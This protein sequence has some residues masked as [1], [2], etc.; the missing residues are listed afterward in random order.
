GAE[1]RVSFARPD[2]PLGYGYPAVTSAFRSNYPVYDVRR[3]DRDHVVLT[4]GTRPLKDERTEDESAGESEDALVVSGGVRN[5]DDLEGHPAILDVPV[6][7]GHVIAF[8]FNPLHRDLNHSDY[9]F[10]WNALLNWRHILD[11]ENP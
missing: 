6:G 10:L 5:G 11:A 2:H 1:L 9:R 3:A 7:D 8:N 4:W